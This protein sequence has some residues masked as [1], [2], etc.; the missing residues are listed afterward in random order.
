LSGA[1]LAAEAG[2]GVG[3]GRHRDRGALQV[4]HYEGNIISTGGAVLVFV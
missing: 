2:F 1:E 3:R 4:R